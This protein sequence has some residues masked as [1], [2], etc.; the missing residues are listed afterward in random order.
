M[1]PKDDRIKSPTS[2]SHFWNFE[3]KAANRALVASQ[4]GCSNAWAHGNEP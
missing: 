2:I 4:C 3:D 1:T